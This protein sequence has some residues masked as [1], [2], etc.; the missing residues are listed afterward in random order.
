MVSPLV[1][2][3]QANGNMFL[4]ISVYAQQ[5][6]SVI[7]ATLLIVLFIYSRSEKWK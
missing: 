2:Y 6:V 5:V 3:I 1:E 7:A 4:G